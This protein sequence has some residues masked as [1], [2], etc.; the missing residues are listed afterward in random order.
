MKTLIQYS[1]SK[2]VI[3]IISTL[4][5]S[6]GWNVALTNTQDFT[7]FATLLGFLHTYERNIYKNE[8]TLEKSYCVH[9]VYIKW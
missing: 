7:K 1:M 2:G 4:H 8:P 5:Q 3:D 6:W 9:I